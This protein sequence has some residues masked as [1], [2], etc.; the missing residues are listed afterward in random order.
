MPPRELTLYTFAMSHFCEKIR[1]TLD[2]CGLP[3]RERPMTPM[4]HAMAAWRMGGRGRTSLPILRVN[5][6]QTSADYI[7]DSTRILTWLD[8]EAGPNDLI[9][10][11]ELAQEVSAIE[12]RFD[13]VGQDVT[14]LIYAHAFTQGDRLLSF[15]SSSATAWQ[16]RCLKTAWPLIRVIY[17]HQLNLTPDGLDQAEQRL[18][19]ALAWLDG[20]LSDGR[21]FLVGHR[22]TV[23]DVAVASL[24]APLACPDEHPVFSQ[25]DF[26]RYMLPRSANWLRE[27]PAFR[28]VRQMYALHRIALPEGAVATA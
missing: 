21:T 25:A 12:S 10:R 27:R 19:Q 4:F 17:R 26:K 28:W 6:R 14:R 16:R 22:L 2:L 20:R 3:Y 13:R 7:Q 15:W 9:P 24:L 8:R 18:Q 11:C 23:A 5:A 1:W